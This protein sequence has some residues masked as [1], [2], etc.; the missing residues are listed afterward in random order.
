MYGIETEIALQTLK[1][2]GVIDIDG[3]RIGPCQIAHQACLDWQFLK[4]F[5][6]S[7]GALQLLLQMPPTFAQVQKFLCQQV[8]RHTLA[9]G[10]SDNAHGALLAQ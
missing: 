10:P 5:R 7:F 3:D 6:G 8:S 4:Y 1:N 9:L 2:I